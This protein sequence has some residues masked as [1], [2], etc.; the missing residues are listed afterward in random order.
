MMKCFLKCLLAIMLI[1]K[2][3]LAIGEVEKIGPS[4]SHPWG[5]AFLS[6]DNIL[7]T[8]RAG[9][10]F[11]ITLSSGAFTEIQNLPKV[12]H[13][14]QGGLLDVAVSDDRVFLCYAKEIGGGAATA[15]DSAR[16][17]NNE[18]KGRMTIFTS[19]NSPDSAHHFGCRLTISDNMIYASLGDRGNRYNAQNPYI[20]DGSIIRIA[21]DG[22]IPETNPKKDGWQS[23]IYSIG[24][25]NPQGMT[26]HAE[27][28]AIWTHE[29]GPQG[30]DEINIIQK[31]ENYGW[32]VVSFG[33]E[34]GT[35]TAVSN[36]TT[37]PDMVDPIWV[38]KPSIAPS[39]MAF[40][41]SDGTM[42]P[43]LQGSLLVGSLKFKRLY[44][45][46]LDEQGLPVSEMPIIDG[47]L[48]RIRDVAIAP[49]GAILLL[50]DAGKTNQPS[51]G[52]YRISK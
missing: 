44:K 4:L 31:G 12:A 30:G 16:L 19:N 5:M 18:L 7:V 52:L 24:H 33:D 8:T 34:Y 32:P 9:Q 50:N 23:E 47:T 15:I 40:Y 45:I 28:G 42:F 14:G 39:G 36:L 43:A 38:W 49:D 26:Q 22:S 13:W 25:R 48:G 17:E 46:M 29:H 51:G 35:G 21:L 11:N 37:H 27:T 41:P 10:L 1:P 3:A 2:I 6:T 20:H